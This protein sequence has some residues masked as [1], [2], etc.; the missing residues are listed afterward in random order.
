MIRMCVLTVRRPQQL[1]KLDF[2]DLRACS[3]CKPHSVW[4]GLIS[5]E[6]KDID[7]YIYIYIN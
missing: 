4:I 1:T 5:R 6:C 3:K 7:T 2:S